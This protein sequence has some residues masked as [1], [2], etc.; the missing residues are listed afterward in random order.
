[1]K[2]AYLMDMTVMRTLI[3]ITGYV[4]KPLIRNHNNIICIIIIFIDIL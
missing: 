1:L 4:R 2:D 3:S